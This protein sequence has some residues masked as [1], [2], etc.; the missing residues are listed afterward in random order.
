[1]RALHHCSRL[2]RIVQ[3]SQWV[4][5]SVKSH[6]VRRD[7]NSDEAGE[8]ENAGAEAGLVP[9]TSLA[10][11]RDVRL[12]SGLPSERRQPFKGDLTLSTQNNLCVTRKLY[13]QLLRL[14]DLLGELQTCC[15]A[16]TDS[17]FLTKSKFEV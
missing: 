16:L 1:M 3:F 5:D 15:R 6:H 9:E 4:R 11:E 2:S 12:Q 8:L 7:V 10:G 13:K 17:T 14:L